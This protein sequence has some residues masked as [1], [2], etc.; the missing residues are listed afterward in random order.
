MTAV[1]WVETTGKTIEEALDAALD[2]LGVDIDEVEY[3][4]L[5]EPKAG[6][7]G[8]M[9]SEARIRARVRPTKPRAKEERRDRRRK[10]A[11]SA[12]APA[13]DAAAAEGADDESADAAPVAA[14]EE[15]A[16]GAAKPKRA[17]AATAKK[18][19]AVA[20]PSAPSAPAVALS[21]DEAAA[22]DEV[23]ST[24]E[25]FLSGLLPLFGAEVAYRRR[26]I[27]AVTLELE[28]TGR[29]LGFLIGP[30][31]QT[32][33]AIQELAR[34]VVHI[35]LGDRPVRL[36]L[37]VSGYRARRRVALEQFTRQVADEVVQSGEARRLEPMTASDRK[38]VHDVANTIA[39]VRTVSEGEDPERQVVILPA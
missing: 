36:M 18:A 37:D 28:V 14:S 11:A 24:A 31:A 23:A 13:G 34:T 32:L 21:E 7:F 4:V 9:R 17:K 6:L 39:G 35:R 22:L 33:L 30:K 20:A 26:I 38:I 10:P 25:E 29:D 27:D 3:E 12:A 1:E 19:A 16:P 15:V 5:D 2:E 8:R